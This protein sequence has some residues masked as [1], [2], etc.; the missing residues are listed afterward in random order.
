[1]TATPWF[2]LTD[3]RS[4]G[5]QVTH[6]FP[7][8]PNPLFTSPMPFAHENRAG[9]E[10]QSLTSVASSFTSIARNIP[11]ELL[12][13]NVGVHGDAAD[14]EK[15]VDVLMSDEGVQ[16]IARWLSDWH[17]LR[18]LTDCGMFEEVGPSYSTEVVSRHLADDFALPE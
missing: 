11:A 6:G 12:A 16:K 13:G 7:L 18:F 15:E 9:L 1:M 4:G 8:A 14:R 5:L 10:D 3:S 17:L 2:R